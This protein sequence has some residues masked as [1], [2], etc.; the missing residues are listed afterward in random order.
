MTE[1]FQ[2]PETFQLIC[3]P[4]HIQNRPT[5]WEIL[6]CETFQVAIL[7]GHRSNGTGPRG[8]PT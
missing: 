1:T 6:A 5:R 4:G 2:T 8:Q 3:D 7:R